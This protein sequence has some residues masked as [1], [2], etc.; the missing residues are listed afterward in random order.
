M[1]HVIDRVCV[2]VYI[3]VSLMAGLLKKFFM[4]FSKKYF[5]RC[6][7]LYLICVIS[8]VLHN[9]TGTSV[10][11]GSPLTDCHMKLHYIM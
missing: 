11:L 1:K 7:A 6:G 5:W 2:S 4:D 8:A 9:V 3:C 10:S